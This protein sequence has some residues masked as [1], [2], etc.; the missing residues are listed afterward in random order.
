[1]PLLKLT[2]IIP[3]NNYYKFT[4]EPFSVRFGAC[5]L[6]HMSRYIYRF[7]SDMG[8]RNCISE[9]K[10]FVPFRLDGKEIIIYL[11]FINC[12]KTI[13]ENKYKNKG[14]IVIKKFYYTFKTNHYL[15]FNYILL[16]TIKKQAKIEMDGSE[17]IYP[18]T[19]NILIPKG[20][21][22]ERYD[23]RYEY[24]I[25]KVDNWPFKKEGIGY[26]INKFAN[27]KEPDFLLPDDE[28]FV[29]RKLYPEGKDFYNLII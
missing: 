21:K 2:K 12:E 26:V 1:M 9:V 23:P 8:T 24:I 10:N 7:L 4:F 6:V 19:L 29:L 22:T 28:K 18:E 3:I 15:T 20:E 13:S 16:K 14:K 27:R 17:L 5:T 11:T 25:W